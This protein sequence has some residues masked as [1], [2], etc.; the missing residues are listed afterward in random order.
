MK[1]EETYTEQIS[2]PSVFFWVTKE[3]L[4]GGGYAAA[5]VIV[6]GVGYGLLYGASLLLPVES[7]EAP[8]P[9]G[10]MIRGLP[11]GHALI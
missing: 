1:S 2:K 3:M 4:R 5:F 7:K 11:D 9:M 6:I 8:P 10:F